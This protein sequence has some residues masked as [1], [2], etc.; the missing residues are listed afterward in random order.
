MTLRV[1]VHPNNL[2]LQLAALAWPDA[3][4]RGMQFISYP[5]GRETG[6]LLQ[7]GVIEFGGTGSTPPL[8]AQSNGID[9]VYVAASAARGANGSIVVRDAGP[10]TRIADLA[11]RRVA[12]LDGSFHTSFLAAALQEHG[13]RLDAVTRVELAPAASMS[14]LRDGEVDAW[15]AMEPHLSLVREDPALRTISQ[16]GQYVSNRS[17][18][19]ASRQAVLQRPAAL[20]GLIRDLTRLGED[21]ARHPERY[22]AL[23]SAAGIGGSGQAIWQ[24]ALARR[25]WRLHAIDAEILDEQQAEADLLLAHQALPRAIDVRQAFLSLNASTP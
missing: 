4:A 2:H 22:A 18:F 6:R 7:E 19:W 1:G 16:I 23:L 21:V 25:D 20:A 3:A 17:I 9:L 5:E 24:T 15:I 10:I 14:A 13:L 11:G 12:L 8:L